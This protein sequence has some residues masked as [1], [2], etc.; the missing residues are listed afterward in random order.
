Q[1]TSLA[2][3]V[4]TGPAGAIEHAR[5][6]NVVGRLVPM[7]AIG[8]VVAAPLA[9]ALAQMLPHATLVRAFALFLLANAI[10]TWLRAGRVAPAVAAQT[11][12]EGGR[13]AGQPPPGSTSAIHLPSGSAPRAPALTQARP[14]AWRFRA[15]PGGRPQSPPAPASP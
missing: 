11:S 15:P 8:A 6:G 10:A 7:L 5:H 3:I 2:A 13:N 4:V 12:L 9:S 1:G 14:R